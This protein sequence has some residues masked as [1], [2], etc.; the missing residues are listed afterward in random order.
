VPVS[1]RRIA[2]R[3][4]SGT[5]GARAPEDQA[6]LHKLMTRLREDDVEYFDLKAS[7]ASCCACLAQPCLL[8][9]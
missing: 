3:G 7:G 6:E 8:C 9:D 2:S 5:G 4:E 1:R